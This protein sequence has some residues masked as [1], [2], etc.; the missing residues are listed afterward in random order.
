MLF[1]TNSN[2]QVCCNESCGICTKPGGACILK[3]CVTGPKCGPALCPVGE[4]CC[5]ESCGICTK[6]GGACPMIG[7]LPEP[8]G[9]KCGATTCNVG[10]VSLAFC[11]L[12]L[13][14]YQTTVSSLKVSNLQKNRFAVM[15]LAA[16]AL[17]LE[18]F[19]PSNSAVPYHPQLSLPSLHL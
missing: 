13:S 16:F 9:E 19:A 4:T 15:P 2:N 11:C 7:C 14:E 3:L 6:P 18:E 12:C 5:N 1:F 10:D 17:H 8:V